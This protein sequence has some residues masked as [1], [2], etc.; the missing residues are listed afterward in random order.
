MKRVG[1]LHGSNMI[2]LRC[3]E[4]HT[5]QW[6][7]TDAD[8]LFEALLQDL[9][10]TV[11]RM[12]REFKAFVRAQKVKTPKHLLSWLLFFRRAE[13]SRI[14]P[15]VGQQRHT[16]AV[17]SEKC[18]RLRGSAW[19]SM[20]VIAVFFCPHAPDLLTWRMS[21]LSH[22]FKRLERFTKLATSS[23]RY[24]HHISSAPMASDREMRH[25]TR[26]QTDTLKPHHHCRFPRRNH[27]LPTPW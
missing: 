15:A 23:I 25:G 6:P 17:R 11:S 13:A 22:D 16:S 20:R 14:S 4:Q 19:A 21:V 18:V 9:P 27:L 12:A 26:H 1:I 24:H 7:R 3:K 10:P 2:L 8:T 5:M